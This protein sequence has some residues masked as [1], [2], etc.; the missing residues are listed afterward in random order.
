MASSA[1]AEATNRSPDKWEENTKQTTNSKKKKKIAYKQKP[2]KATSKKEEKKKTQLDKYKKRKLKALAQKMYKNVQKMYEQYGHGGMTTYGWH[3]FEEKDVVLK[4][5]S[6]WL[7]DLMKD[8]KG[9]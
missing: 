5:D 7:K 9:L 6:N 2:T 8:K 4:K 3:R 1:Y